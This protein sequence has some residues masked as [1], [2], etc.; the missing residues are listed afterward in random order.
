[1]FNRL[2]NL[3]LFFAALFYLYRYQQMSVLDC[4]LSI[5]DVPVSVR[6]ENPDPAL[7][8]SLSYGQITRKFKS[9]HKG[10]YGAPGVQA[11]GVTEFSLNV[12][13]GVQF[14]E[15]LKS[16]TG[17]I[18]LVPQ[19]VEITIVLDQTIFLGRESVGKACQY[20]TLMDHELRHVRINRDVTQGKISR[21]EDVAREGLSAFAGK[22][23]GWGPYN[24]GEVQNRKADLN[25]AMN[26]AINRGV[27]ET[28]REIGRLQGRVDTPE[29]Y[30][31]IGQA[32]R[33]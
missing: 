19:S 28:E 9:F 1:M 15:K 32:C 20:K 16:F 26:N 33:W 17:Q 10:L 27:K 11:L 31:R 30:R 7:D 13:L 23:G 18:C 22:E 3:F 8:T 2:L 25:S 24:F 4:N 14:V 21:F 29:E 12:R 6:F 5:D